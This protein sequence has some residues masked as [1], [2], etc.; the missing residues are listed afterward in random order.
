MMRAQW[1][2]RATVALAFAAAPPLLAQPIYTDIARQVG[3]DF[4]HDPGMEGKHMAPEVMGSGC[5]FLDYDNDGDLDVYL[6]QAGPLPESKKPRPPDRLYRQNADGKFTDVTAESGL[7]DTGYGTG[8]AVGRHR[9]RRIRRR[10]RHQLRPEQPL[11][12]SGK[13]KVHERH[14]AVRGSRETTGPRRR[15]SATTTTTVSSTSTSR[16]T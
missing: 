10:L 14:R 4:V 11:P 9:Q 16:T 12:Q 13:R 5:A 2:S 3:I 8:V 15:R 7:G 6:V 1:C